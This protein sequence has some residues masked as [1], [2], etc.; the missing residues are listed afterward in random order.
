MLYYSNS[1]GAI[2]IKASNRWT[3][4]VIV[5]TCPYCCMHFLST[6]SQDVAISISMYTCSL[7]VVHVCAC[8]T[9]IQSVCTYVCVLYLYT[10]SMYSCVRALP[11]Y[12][13]YVLVCALYVCTSLCLLKPDV[14]SWVCLWPVFIKSEF[15]CMYRPVCVAGIYS[16]SSHYFIF[17]VSH[18]LI[19]QVAAVVRIL[20]IFVRMSVQHH[21]QYYLI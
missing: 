5:S 13:Q 18:C 21:W 7:C 10:V 11:V 2:M 15:K 12:S 20:A 4:I 14:Q 1:R 6:Y 19:I 16:D 9:C 8:F 17:L 3:G